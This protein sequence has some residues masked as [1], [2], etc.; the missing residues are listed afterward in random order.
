MIAQSRLVGVDDFYTCGEAEDR[1]EKSIET[2]LTR[3]DHLGRILT[4][5]EA[6]RE[7]SYA[8]HGKGPSQKTLEK[9]KRKMND[10]FLAKKSNL[11]QESQ[12]NRLKAV[13]KVTRHLN[14]SQ[15]CGILTS[16]PGAKE[17]V[18]C[19]VGRWADWA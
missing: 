19:F 7:I 2:A 6:F 18:C 17:C 3:K 10:D 13:Q 1:L 12:L 15:L 9:R 11:D 4:P 14:A 8:F 5:K 16:R